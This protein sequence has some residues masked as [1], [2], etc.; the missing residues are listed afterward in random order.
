MLTS[1]EARRVQLPA[2]ARRMG[3]KDAQQVRRLK[4]RLEAKGLLCVTA[5]PG[6]PDIIKADA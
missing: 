6:L 4:H 3:Y 2:L 5:R 1:A